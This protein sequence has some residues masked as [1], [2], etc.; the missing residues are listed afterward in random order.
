MLTVKIEGLEELKRTISDIGRKQVP[1]AAAKAITK[2]AKAVEKRVQSDM[3]GAFKSASPFVKRATF[4]TSA[5]KAS[6]TATVGLKDQ[7]PAGGSAPAVLLKEH[8]TGGLR[9]NKPFEKALISM[10]VMPIGYRA[11]PGRGMRLNA[12]GN[13]T[14]ESIRRVLEVI[15]TGQIYD[16]GVNTINSRSHGRQKNQA[17]VS[18][19]LKKV[20]DRSARSNNLEP[21]IYRR[22]GEGREN[23]RAAIP[24][25]VFVKSAA[26]RKVLDMERSAR[27]VVAR[28]F[29][30]N[31]DVAFAEA[32][33]TAR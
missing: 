14:R 23:G 15:K 11:I 10:G 33:R 21:G 4:S 5:T 20:G 32:M 12:Y 3:A 22:I 31:F 7:K 28:E 26:Y 17:T 1:F 29:Q 13:P 19:F 9:G 2:T 6:L 25:L 24:V 8:F 30:P 27:E 16:G 18:Y